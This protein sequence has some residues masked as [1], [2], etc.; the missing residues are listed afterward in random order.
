MAVVIQRVVGRRH[1]DWVYPNFAGVA[2]S[3][4]HY[5]TEAMRQEDGVCL[6]VLG[7]GRTVVDGGQCLRFSPR[8]PQ[9]IL[10]FATVEDT[11]RNSQSRF[12]ALD[13]GDPETYPD[14][15]EEA[16][17][18]WLDLETAERHG[19]LA[20]VGS[21]Y[22]AENDA[23][24]DG[25][26]RA[27]P[28][29]V[30]FAHVLKSGLFPLADIVSFLL[31]LSRR[32]MSCEVE[33]EFAVNLGEGDDPPE[34]GLL[35]VRPLAADLAAPD[36]SDEIYHADEAVIA[37]RLALGNGQY[38]SIRDIVLV[39]RERFDRGH[40][41][42]IAREVGVFN[43]RLQAEGRPYL[44]VGP[45]RWGS[46]DRWLGVPVTWAQIAGAAVIVETDL[47]EFKVTPSQGTHFFQN[48]TAF[49]VGY[50]T[51]NQSSGGGILDWEWLEARPVAER[52]EHL[53]HIRL[54][55]PLLVLIDGRS[56]RGV[57]LGPDA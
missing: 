42:E 16:N 46:S 17:V 33:M 35:Q 52:T 38:D 21:V 25:I 49:R 23:V 4:N 36:V 51:V 3:I 26:G 43:D 44:L 45:G 14:P 50:L 11:L 5:A 54:D 13:V 57:V 8:E 27:G 18:T 19:T 41:R 2:H 12:Q 32:C 55:D 40:T 10:Q 20:P 56:G 37:T 6:A 47:E 24:Y 7:L 53:R 29:L 9:R 15:D 31:A 28:R 22:S 1:E 39:D 30:S 48:L 34:F